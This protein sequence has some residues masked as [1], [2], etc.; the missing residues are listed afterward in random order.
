MGE[1]LLLIFLALSMV[2]SLTGRSP[3][4]GLAA[5]AFGLLLGS[6]GTA[7]ATGELRYTFDTVYLSDGIPLVVLALGVFAMPEIIDL[8]RQRSSIAATQELGS[9]WR[10]GVGDALKHWWLVT[11]VSGSEPSSA[12][13]RVLAHRPPMAGLRARRSVLED[14][15]QFGK[16]DIR[17]VIAPEAAN[18]A[19]RGGDLVPTLSSAF[20]VP[21]RWRCCSAPSS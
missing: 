2:G 20:R 18:N 19:V 8:M 17:G 13:C 21:A 15:S 10:Q 1:Q 5:C 6:V 11:R 7:P 3:V 16:G 4:K 12:C 14:K 9:G